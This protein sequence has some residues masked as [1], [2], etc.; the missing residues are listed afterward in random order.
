MEAIREIRERAGVSQS[1]LASLSGVRQP[2][3]AAYESGS[4]RLTSAMRDRLVRAMIRPSELVG[5]HRAG[6]CEIVENNRGSRPRIV[7]SVA[8]GED[9]PGSDL[10]LLVDLDDDASLLDL[11]RMHLE[12]EDLL[13]VRVDVLDA[14]ALR[15]K[16][17]GILVDAMPL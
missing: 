17:R 6:I 8:R 7:G 12:L 13:G 11:A 5:L 16:H 10:D 2:N 4:R 15:E 14:A 9:R 1:E 3:I